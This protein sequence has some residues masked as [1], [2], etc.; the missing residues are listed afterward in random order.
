MYR[1]T[2]CQV[3]AGGCLHTCEHSLCKRLLFTCGSSS[4]ASCR[5]VRS[6]LVRKGPI[7]HLCTIHSVS[8]TLQHSPT[9][10]G[11]WRI[12]ILRSG[13]AEWQL[14]GRPD[15]RIWIHLGLE[16]F[17][18]RKRHEISFIVSSQT[19]GGARH[20]HPILLELIMILVTVSWLLQ[21]GKDCQCV[22]E[23]CAMPETLIWWDVILS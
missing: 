6:F 7:I 8:V 1:T 21:N 12:L 2:R 15:L 5:P 11:Q 22:N 16:L 3:Q 4:S 19:M 14:E 9:P 23:E 18:A 13:L 10:L 20:W 17:T